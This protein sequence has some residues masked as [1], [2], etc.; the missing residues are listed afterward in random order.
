[1]TA[2]NTN[3]FAAAIRERARVSQN[4]TVSV[5]LNELADVVEKVGVESLQG[6]QG[7]QGAKGDTGAQGPAGQNAIPLTETKQ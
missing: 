5:V 2:T 3:V 1:M 7:E 4:D 6:P